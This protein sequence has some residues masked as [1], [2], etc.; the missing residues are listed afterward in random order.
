[1]FKQYTFC[2]FLF[3]ILFLST[4]DGYAQLGGFG[5]SQQFRMGEG[6][7][8]IAEP[9]QLAD[10]VSVWGD[11]NAPG[12]YVVP[13]GTK[14]HELIS[15]ARGPIQAR[16]SSQNID[17]NKLRVEI[18]IS[19]FNR[20]TGNETIR[21]YK[22]R[23]NEPYPAEL[24]NYL[25]QNDEIVSIELKRRPAFIDYLRVTATIVSTAATTFLIIDRL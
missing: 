15:Y 7:V 12:R 11:V 23:Y 22:F 9:G 14:A 19:R 13:R 2:F 16:Y 6:L 5:D 25:L 1:M 4:N 20:Q 10:T 8:R 3:L 21:S 24:R 18:T 17:W